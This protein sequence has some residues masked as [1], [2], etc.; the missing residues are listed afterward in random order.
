LILSYP[1][2]L[3]DRLLSLVLETMVAGGEARAAA[4]FLAA[5]GADP[6]L[7]LARAMQHEATGDTD[8]AL[9]IYD[10]LALNRD[11]RLR[12]RGGAG[13]GTAARRWPD[14]QE[15]GGGCAG[16]AAVRLARRP[17]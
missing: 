5:H 15:S 10:L 6:A 9:A 16:P 13:G 12:A 11:R 3:R 1:E 2:T 4:P 7:A 17:P 14:R 8:G